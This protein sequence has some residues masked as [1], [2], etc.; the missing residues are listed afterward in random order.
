MSDLRPTRPKYSF[1]P[2]M[3][4]AESCDDAANLYGCDRRSIHRYQNEGVTVVQIEDLCAE[5]RV[6]PCEV[7]G[8]DEWI[9][10][11]QESFPACEVCDEETARLGHDTCS[12]CAKVA[13][14][15]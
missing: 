7:Y 4:R 1:D 5:A 15:A 11:I 8:W 13:V 12:A 3:A 14:P 9:G 10:M 2:L 6:H